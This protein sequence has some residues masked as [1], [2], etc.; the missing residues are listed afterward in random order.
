MSHAEVAATRTNFVAQAVRLLGAAL[1]L[2][3]CAA[4]MW[5][6]WLGWDHAYYQVDGVAQGPYRAW[7]VIGCGISIAAAAVL[8]HL[9]VRGVWSV[10]VL[11]AAAVI[12]FAVP[13][14]RDAASTDDSGLWVVGLVFLLV[15]GGLGL[16]ALLTISEGVAGTVSRRSSR[17]RSGHSS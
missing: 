13:W 15:G 6:A 12:G 1:A 17:Q 14:A 5:F 9:A 4:A 8:A 10:L 7:Q 16:V 11:P 3:L 2:G